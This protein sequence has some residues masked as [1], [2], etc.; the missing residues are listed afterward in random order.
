M[1]LVLPQV[2]FKA[3]ISNYLFLSGIIF[4]IIIK[5]KCSPF[6][7]GIIQKSIMSI[8][9]VTI[10]LTELSDPPSY[11]RT[12]TVSQVPVVLKKYIQHLSLMNDVTSSDKKL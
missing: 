8:N 10:P 3:P 5:E 7:Q 1:P 12:E 9:K 6:N 4:D 11:F 2:S